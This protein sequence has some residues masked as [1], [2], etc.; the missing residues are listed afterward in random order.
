MI[1]R[2]ALAAVLALSALMATA[3]AEPAPPLY[4]DPAQPVEA[5]VD[6]LLG[7]MTLEEKI[8]LVH[9]DSKFT[10]AAIPRLGIPRFWMSDGPHG[11]RQEMNANDWGAAG[12][13]DDY[14]TWLPN[15]LGLAAT[16][17]TDL[18]N[19]Y[20]QTIGAEARARGKQMML[21]PAIN[22]QRTPLG[23]RNFEYLGEDPF[24][25]SRMAVNYIEG[26]QSQGIA[27][28]V[29]HYACNNQ[30]TERNSVDVELDERTLREI[31]LPGFK[32]AVKEAHVLGVMAAYNKVRGQYCA[33][34]AYLLKTILKDEWGFKGLV[35]SDWGAVHDTIQTAENGLDLEMGTG[36]KLYENYYLANPLL[37]AIQSGQVPVSALDEMVRRNLRVRF[38][39]H[40]FDA[41]TTGPAGSINTKEHHLI[42]RRVADE[43]MVLLKNDGATLPLDPDKISSIAVIGENASSHFALRG[44]SAQI[45]ALYEVPPLEGIL[46][47]VGAAVNVSYSIGYMQP[48]RDTDPLPGLID[49]AVEAAKQ[50]QVVVI[51]A[52][53]NHGDNYDEEGSDREDLRLPPGQ[54]ELIERV[55]AANPRTIVVLMSG[56]A[57]EMPWLD[58]VPAVIQ[59]WYPGMEGGN[60]LAGILF[61]D[62][63]PSGKLSCT[64]PKK[65]A[66]S[67]AHALDAFPGED[68]VEHYA[69]GLLVGYRWFDT[70]NVEPLFPFGYGLSYTK[71]DYA[72]L[73][74][75]AASG[76]ADATSPVVT[77]QCQVT[78]SGARQGAEVV[79]VYVHADK[80]ALPRPDQELKG[81]AR[82]DPKAGE[83]RTV[84][85]P[86]GR[87]AFSYYD[88]AKHEWVAEQGTYTIRVGGSSR[89]IRLQSPFTLATT[90][91]DPE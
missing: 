89:D 70:K 60:A 41:P 46:R 55:V 30:E 44:G 80:P 71:F 6:D 4:L 72:D 49:R 15:L 9:G 51:V 25:T 21:G 86:L 74:L 13:T 52:G 12:H 57:I 1:T 35:V 22:I 33:Q 54:D 58:H 84:S 17:D 66:D 87:G 5:R 28:C 88:P 47:R 65:L 79:Q 64:F 82:V 32:A 19:S 24:L 59:A 83:T 56:G 81:F 11:V 37:H 42:A 67:P 78:N 75:T 18:A 63:N 61:G 62:V 3:R 73:K 77:V 34:N 31:Y 48:D 50:A 40:V 91:V 8:S 68:G 39:I 76:D 85:I 23:G 36:Q 27:S 45:K 38:L 69:E 10:T 16:F 43:A 20:G 14:S 90:T 53:L 29:K 26:E 2:V 7:R